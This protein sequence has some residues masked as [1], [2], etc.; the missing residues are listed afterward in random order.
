MR[1]WKFLFLRASTWQNSKI[2]FWLTGFSFYINMG[3]VCH[4]IRT[5]GNNFSREPFIF[6]ILLPCTIKVWGRTTTREWYLMPHYLL[7]PAPACV[8]YSMLTTNPKTEVMCWKIKRC[9]FQLLRKWPYSK[10]ACPTSIHTHWLLTSW[11]VALN[12]LNEQSVLSPPFSCG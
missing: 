1:P 11:P 5:Q 8:F 9:S 6:L 12:S 2:N 10:K 4:N 3:R 7:F